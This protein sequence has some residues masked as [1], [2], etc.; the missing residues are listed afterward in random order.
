MRIPISPP[1]IPA[2]IPSLDG[3]RAVSILAVIVGHSV[4]TYGGPNFLGPLRHMGN[5]GVRMFFVISG[6]LITTLL[7]KELQRSGG[8]SLKEFYIRR[9]L[10]IWPAFFAFVGVVYAIYLLG[11]VKLNPGDLLHSVTFTMNY[12]HDD[13]WVFSH[14]WSLSVEEQF[15]LLWPLAL[16]MLGPRSAF[17][18][19]C[20]VLLASPLARAAMWYGWGV[21]DVA[22]MTR[23]FQ[24]VADSL[25]IGCLLS[26]AYNA[27]LNHVRFGRLIR[28]AWSVVFA[29]VF[30][31]GSFAS[32]FVAPA[33]FYVFTQSIANAALALLVIHFVANHDGLIGRL[34][35]SRPLVLIGTLSYSL[36]L[37]QNLFM[38]PDS[39][40][41][42]TRFPSNLFLTFA[43]ATISYLLIE[44]PFQALRGRF[45]APAKV[46]TGDGMAN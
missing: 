42:F 28:S 12:H 11:Y 39:N 46:R 4:D 14:L 34:L 19:A 44:R 45:S 29:A 21:S 2:R 13:A 41:W 15:Y 43:A 9:T 40:H 18:L 16:S 36:Y 38:N 6:F 27:L 31:A 23:Q 25:A 26:C 1:A 22:A 30:L 3:L 32:Y 17:A 37:W 5:L 20:A 8:I 7:L 35:N 33:W 10:R 24:A